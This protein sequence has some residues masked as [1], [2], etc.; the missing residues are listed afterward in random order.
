MVVGRH[1]TRA[2]VLIAVCRSS[3][4]VLWH[5]VAA[6][7]IDSEMRTAELDTAQSSAL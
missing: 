4:S 6:V 1:G 2:H 3:R 5:S 7:A